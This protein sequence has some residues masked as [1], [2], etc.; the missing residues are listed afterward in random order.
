MSRRTATFTAGCGVVLAAAGPALAFTAAAGPGSA[1]R[2]GVRA[3]I[4][5]AD[6]LLAQVKGLGDLGTVLTP[7]TDLLNQVLKADNGQVSTDGA[8]QLDQAVKDAVA[9][10]VADVPRP[11]A[12]ASAT[13]DEPTG[14][15][16]AG[17][18]VDAA[19]DALVKAATSGSPSGAALER[20]VKNLLHATERFEEEGNAEEL[21]Q[22]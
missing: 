21:A 12:Q 6:A 10:A 7:V 15:D 16:E 17:R 3:P 20:D 1:V 2:S 13:G 19:A 14:L 4:P 22:P 8:A 18:A 11:P 5:G 9:R